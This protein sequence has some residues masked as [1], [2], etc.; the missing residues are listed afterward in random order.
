VAKDTTNHLIT[1]TGAV[2][3][4][5]AVPSGETEMGAVF[6][7]DVDGTD[8]NAI[9]LFWNDATDLATNTGDFTLTAHATNKFGYLAI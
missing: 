8:A 6:F 5:S 9:P 3:T 2:I 7:V 4:W 1:F